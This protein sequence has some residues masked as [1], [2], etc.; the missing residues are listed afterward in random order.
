MRTLD[1]AVAPH[2]KKRLLEKGY[3]M[4]DVMHGGERGKRDEEI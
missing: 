2:Q 4:G 3:I 1:F